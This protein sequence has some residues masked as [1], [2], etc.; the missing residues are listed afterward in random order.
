MWTYRRNLF[1]GLRLAVEASHSHSFTR[2]VWCG[3]WMER[4]KN[5]CSRKRV[6]ATKKYIE[7][8]LESSEVPSECAK[9]SVQ[10]NSRTCQHFPQL[11]LN[12]LR[13]SKWNLKHRQIGVMHGVVRHGALFDW[14]T[15]EFGY[16]TFDALPGFGR[17]A[18]SV[19]WHFIVWWRLRETASPE[20]TIECY[21]SVCLCD[22]ISLANDKDLLAPP[23]LR[24]QSNR[25]I[26]RWIWGERCTPTPLFIKCLRNFC[27]IYSVPSFAIY[28][29]FGI[30]DPNRRGIAADRRHNVAL[31]TMVAR[32]SSISFLSIIS[33]RVY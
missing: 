22:C 6:A 33:D 17:W 27:I 31:M 20:Y 7:H 8:I 15:R 19:S 5:M 21:V 2:Q 25:E 26:K 29:Q 9:E 11:S 23:T 30:Y 18:F 10:L 3:G 32:A 12:S 28:C 24:R 13:I 14:G 1:A 4:I 16:L